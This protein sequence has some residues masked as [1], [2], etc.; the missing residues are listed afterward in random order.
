MSDRCSES[1]K[2]IYRSHDEIVRDCGDRFEPYMCRY[3]C[4]WHRTKS[5]PEKRAVRRAALERMVRDAEAAGLY[6]MPELALG[7]DNGP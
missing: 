4:Y 3:C 7:R 2:R 6:D 5:D 1:G